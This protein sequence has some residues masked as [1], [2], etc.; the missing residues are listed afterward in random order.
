MKQQIA[1]S[2]RAHEA[3]LTFPH[4]VLSCPPIKQPKEPT[5]I[6]AKLQAD[7]SMGLEIPCVWAIKK[8][9]NAQKA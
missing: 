5:A 6:T 1:E 8:G 3:T 9:T 2:P 4:G 7:S